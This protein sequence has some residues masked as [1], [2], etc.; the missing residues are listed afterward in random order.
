[1]TNLTRTTNGMTALQ[2]SHNA[3]VDL[4]A[5]IGSARGRDLTRGFTAAFRENKDIAV[6]ILQ[7]ARDVRGGAGERDTF[8]SLLVNLA[9]T[10]HEEIV[11]RLIAKVPEIGRWDDLF[12]LIGK[13]E[14]INDAIAETFAQA[15]LDRNGLAAKWLPR[16]GK[17][18]YHFFFNAFGMTPKQYRKTIVGL[19]NVVE[20]KMCA[21][22][23]DSIEFGKIPS[24]AARNYQKAFKKHTPELYQ[25]YIDGL[26]S[27]ATKINAGAI[28]PYDVIR[29]LS[30][31]EGVADA[32]WKALPDYMGDSEE[33]ILAVVD[34]SPS[35]DDR[36]SDGLTCKDVSVSLGM[37]VAERTKGAFKDM[38]IT[39]HSSPNFVDLS[40]C[41]SLR[42]RLSTTRNASWGGSTNLQ[43]TFQLILNTAIKYKVPQADMPTKILIFSDMQFDTAVGNT[44]GSTALQMIEKMY[45]DA[46]Y[47]RPQVVFW[48]LNARF[49]NVPVSFGQDGTMMVTGFSPAVMKSILA[50]GEIPNVTPLDLMLEAVAIPRYDW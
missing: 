24:L 26:K 43:A 17:K 22:E 23:W 37:Y 27:G 7:W 15:L 16:E 38:F 46:G 34:V 44:A 45:R 13:S 41:R 18:H 49:G 40:K 5:Q 50:A 31:V 19:T 1:M 2:S 47:K 33:N 48:N 9:D 39:F 35:M 21:Q 11:L 4:F 20:T 29:G 25:E 30:G 14:K 42:E 8:R 3:C 12:V 6:R 28:F 32:Q 36:A 10:G